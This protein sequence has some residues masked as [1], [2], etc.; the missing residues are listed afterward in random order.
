MAL[1]PQI[2]QAE[3]SVKK[4]FDVAKPYLKVGRKRTLTC[5]S[6]GPLSLLPCC[7]EERR[8]TAAGKHPHLC[9]PCL[10]PPLLPAALPLASGRLPLCA[11]LPRYNHRCRGGFAT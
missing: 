7:L 9:A 2:Q 5:T 3:E 1:P 11:I 4:A 8:G 10:P 6:P